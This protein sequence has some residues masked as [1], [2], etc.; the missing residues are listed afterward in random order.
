MLEHPTPFYNYQPLLLHHLH[1]KPSDHFGTFHNIFLATFPHLG[2][3]TQPKVLQQVVDDL[4]SLLLPDE[5][6]L[7]QDKL[8]P[9]GA[10]TSPHSHTLGIYV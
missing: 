2:G 6:K 10:T 5:V 4:P 7:S 3:T 9:K 1:L 8:W